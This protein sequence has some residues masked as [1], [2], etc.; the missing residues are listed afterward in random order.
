M[1]SLNGENFENRL[2]IYQVFL[3]VLQHFSCI[4]CD[5]FA[6]YVFTSSIATYLRFGWLYCHHFTGN[7]VLF[8]VVKDFLKSVKI[9]QS[10]HQSSAANFKDAVFGPHGRQ[11]GWPRSLVIVASRIWRGIP[12]GLLHLVGMVWS[13]TMPDLCPQ[14]V[15][16]LT[17]A[18]N[19]SLMTAAGQFGSGPLCGWHGHVLMTNYTWLFTLA[20]VVLC[21][22]SSFVLTLF[23][24]FFF[25]YLSFCLSIW[26]NAVSR[27]CSFLSLLSLYLFPS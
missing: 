26:F 15:P 27:A 25:F 7:L 14:T 18:L 16:F 23:L 13:G 9:W 10:S 24:V 17:S 22:R 6:F 1:L 8:P 12:V 5:N 11:A 3:K 20:N 2:R 4:S 19:A 21:S